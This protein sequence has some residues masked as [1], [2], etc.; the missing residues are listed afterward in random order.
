ML[1]FEH[2]SHIFGSL[3]ESHETYVTA[4]RKER[5]HALRRFSFELKA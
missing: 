4:T 5:R 2:L 3:T 1:P